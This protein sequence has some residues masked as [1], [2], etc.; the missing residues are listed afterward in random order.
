MEEM[1]RSLS[2]AL[3][4]KRKV[5]AYGSMTEMMVLA[6]VSKSLSEM[7]C[8]RLLLQVVQKLNSRKEHRILCYMR[9]DLSVYQ[10]KTLTTLGK[11]NVPL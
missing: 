9:I 1:G 5:G 8:Y 6:H 3:G 2:F 10:S 7:I 11:W 4:R